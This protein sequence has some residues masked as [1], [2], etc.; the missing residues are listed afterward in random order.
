MPIE[1]PIPKHLADA[2]KSETLIP[3][4]GAGVSMSILDVSGKRIFP[5]WKE[6]LERA[7]SRI[8]EQGESDFAD[9]IHS[10]I[11]LNRYQTAAELARDGLVGR[12]WV[13]FF[14]EN[15]LVK[16]EQ[17]SDKSLALPRAIWKLSNRIVT[18]NYDKV[19][20][21]AASEPA[22]VIELDNSLITQ[23]ADFD[24]T[25]IQFERIWH[26]HGRI[27]NASS[28]FLLKKVISHYTLVKNKKL[29]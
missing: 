18:L 4:V 26:L 17:I 12:L 23:L 29:P 20:R 6:L 11:R 24:R 5:S 1:T 28:I 14:N 27:D 16:K 15:F 3:I 2:M 8:A 7:A 13:D 22:D 21:L 25:E 19:L 10:M 9:G